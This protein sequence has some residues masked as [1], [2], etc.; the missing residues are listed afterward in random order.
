MPD[1]GLDTTRCVE[2]IYKVPPSVGVLPLHVP[3][4]AGGVCIDHR[5]VPDR[6]EVTR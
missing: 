1:A 6:V 2:S 4:M 3:G 5:S